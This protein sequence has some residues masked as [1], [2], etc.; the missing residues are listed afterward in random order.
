MFSILLAII[1]LAFISLGLP[2]ALLGS[3]L[4]EITRE[5]GIPVSFCGLLYMLISLS[6]ITSTLMSE[7]LVRFFGTGRVTAFSVML[8]AGALIGFP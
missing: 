6:T 3:A 8:T 5:F 2:D 7:K 4:H 1:Y